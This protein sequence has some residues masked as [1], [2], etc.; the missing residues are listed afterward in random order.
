MRSSTNEV[1]EHHVC[2]EHIAE[3]LRV[4]GGENRFGE[5]NFRVVWGYDR[6]VPMT[7]KWEEWAKYGAMLT[8]KM[9]GYTETREFM[10]L[11]KEIVETRYVPK[12]LPGN[13][14]HLEMWRPPE[15][16]GSPEDWR[17]AGEEVLQGMTVDTAG[18][19]PERGEYELCY[20]LTDDAT[21]RGRP[22]PLID[23]LVSELVKMIQF[24]RERFTF[25]QRRAAIEQREARKDEGFIQR[26]MAMFKDS[27][28][29]FAG[30]DFVT[31]PQLV[32]KHGK[33]LIH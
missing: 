25:Q 1:I 32:D 17:K 30:E 16:Y 22:L 8:D 28:R 33:P 11:E 31:V 14:W 24:S 2:P 20:P 12:Y 7:G 15:E 19:F 18:P 6:I 10:K 3:S 9:T 26:T 13:C 27:M 21:S 23:D 29:P 4:A 5:P